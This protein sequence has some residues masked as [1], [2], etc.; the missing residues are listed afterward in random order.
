MMNDK[1]LNEGR[2][3]TSFLQYRNLMGGLPFYGTSGDYQFTTTNRSQFTPG[4]QIKITNLTDMSY[5]G[6]PGMSDFDSMVNTVR[7]HFRVGDRVRGLIVNSQIE[8][9]EGRYAVGRIVKFDINY[10]D[11]TIKVIIKNPETLETQE[12]YFDSMVR[13]YESHKIMRFSE[14][15]K[16]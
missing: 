12:I 16:S 1:I 9:E 10:S 5:N 6:D 8:N 14:Y 13:L 11:R 4:F 7:K 15:L 3:A 2:A